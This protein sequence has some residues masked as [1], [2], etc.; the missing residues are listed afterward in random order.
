LLTVSGVRC[1]FAIACLVAVGGIAAA[2]DI[3]LPRPRPPDAATAAVPAQPA[4]PSACQLRLRPEFAVF[5]P[6]TPIEGPGECGSVDLVRLDSIV[7]PNGAQVGVTPPAVLRCEMAEMVAHWV[8]DSVAP[9]VAE[10]GPPLMGLDNFASYECRGRNRIVGAKISEHG[11]GNALDIR[12]LRIA[13]GRSIG[14]TDVNVPKDFRTGL[15]RSACTRFTTVLGPGSD[16]FHET[17]VHVDLAE[18]SRGHRMCQWDVREPGEVAVASAAGAIPLPRP[19]P[20]L[21]G[22]SET[23]RA[24]LS[25]RGRL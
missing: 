19:R 14:L 15:R 6:L 7:L 5:A 12:S 8:R 10:I 2:R 25:L 22:P 20:V 17:H 18:R 9:V 11:R 4:E 16:G 1:A 13:D 23:V 3:P 24:P 21:Q